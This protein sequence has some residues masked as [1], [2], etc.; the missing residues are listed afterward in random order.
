M[1]AL[2]VA[3]ALVLPGLAAAGPARFAIVAGNNVG[4]AGRAQLWFAENDAERFNKALHEL[5]D[6]SDDR[7]VS[8]KGGTAAVFRE[9]LTTIEHKVAEARASG[10]KPLLVVYFSGHAGPGGLEFGN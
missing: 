10:E 7:V 5:G 1:R 9:A 8:L 6:F 2:A 4:A 3:V